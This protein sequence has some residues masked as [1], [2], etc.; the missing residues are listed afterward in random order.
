[1]RKHKNDDYKYGV[2][3]GKAIKKYGWNNFTYEIIVESDNKNELLELE[4]YYIK[5]YNSKVPNGYNMTDGGEALFDKHNPFFNCKH[6]KKTKEKLSKLAKL[7]TGER[8]PFYGKH[9]QEKTKQLISM[10]NSKPVAML[11]NNAIVKIFKNAISAGEWCYKKGLTKSKYANSDIAKRCKDG[12]KAFGFNWKYV[13]E[14]VETIPDEC[15][16]V[17]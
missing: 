3:L 7:R 4:K 8:N 11:K 6:S 17:E 10:K 2:V 5:Y 16:G 1:M 14:D 13:D 9:H 15:K 12:R